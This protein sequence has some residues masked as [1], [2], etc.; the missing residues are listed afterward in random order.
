MDNFNNFVENFNEKRQQIDLSGNMEEME[1][2]YKESETLLSS[3]FA[4]DMNQ[5]LQEY[6]DQPLHVIAKRVVFLK[7]DY[8]TIDVVS[9]KGIIFSTSKDGNNKTTKLVDMED[10]I[11]E[12]FGVPGEL[13]TVLALYLSKDEF[14]KTLQVYKH[15]IS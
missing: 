3:I 1:T 15:M 14:Y 7:K 2:F 5:L 8:K 11:E 9:N 12:L 4:K 13:K 10:L 6:V